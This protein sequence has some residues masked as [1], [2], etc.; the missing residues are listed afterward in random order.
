MNVVTYCNQR[1]D[2]LVEVVSAESGF[3]EPCH[4]EFVYYTKKA[5]PI[6]QIDRFQV[7]IHGNL[8]WIATSMVIF[9]LALAFGGHMYPQ[10][11]IFL[12]S[13][14]L[15]VLGSMMVFFQAFM[16]GL[17]PNYNFL[18]A[19][20]FMLL[21]LIPAYFLAKYERVGII[22][23]STVCGALFGALIDITFQYK[24]GL[25][26]F[27]SLVI[28]LGLAAGA[29]AFF[30]HD[31]FIILMT[32]FIGSYKFIRGLSY[33]IGGFPKEAEQL[34]FL[35]LNDTIHPYFNKAYYGYFAGILILFGLSTYFQFWKRN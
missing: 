10:H 8:Q 29:A 9:G 18:A 25:A 24:G 4:P 14:N 12:A 6:Y 30:F 26:T 17:N 31:I 34:R 22:W 33:F 11:S 32:S 19:P 16:G 2:E 5:C 35:R 23:M 1:Y 7:M 13:Y 21:G 20:I 15:G 28:I 27:F 3:K